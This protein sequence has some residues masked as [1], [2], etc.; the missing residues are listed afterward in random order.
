MLDES[1]YAQRALRAGAKGYVMKGGRLEE[2]ME[3]IHRVLSGG[4]YLSEKMA[5]KVMNRLVGRSPP[6]E[7]SPV[8]ALSDREMGVFELIGQGLGPSEIAKRLHLSVKTIETYR[9]NIREKIHLSDATALRQYAIQWVQ[10]QK[11]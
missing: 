9:S 4:V 2:V 8:D 3:A 7:D 11:Q 5:A 10:N 6:V 1:F